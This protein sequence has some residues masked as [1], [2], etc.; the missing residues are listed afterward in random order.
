MHPTRDRDIFDLPR[1]SSTSAA[2]GISG[3]RAAPLAQADALASP[4]A[5]SALSLRLLAY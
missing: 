5:S 1:M 3:K 4:A 2:R